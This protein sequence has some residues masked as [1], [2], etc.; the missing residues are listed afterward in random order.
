MNQGN[1]AA[2]GNIVIVGGGTAGWMAANLLQQAW[3]QRYSI[4]LIESPDIGIIGVGE[5]STPQLRGFFQKL[6]LPERDWMPRCHAT[7]KN[8]IRFFDWSQKPGYQAYFHPFVTEV[9]FRT[10]R[11]FVDNAYQR[12]CGFNVH[13][14]PDAFFLPSY[15]AANKRGPK[16]SVN[17]PFDVSYGY[18]F[19]SHLLGQYLSE[20]AVAAGVRHVQGKVAQVELQDS[21]DI[22]AVVL[23]DGQRFA[24]E[25]FVDSTGFRSLLLQQSLQVPFES[26]A[27]N[28]FNDSAVVIPTPADKVPNSE[29][30]ATA[31]SHGWAWNIPLTHRCGNGYVYSS[32]YC[33][34]EVAENELRQHL[35]SK[36]IADEDLGEAR[37][38]KMKV[39]QVQQHWA[40][41]CVAI[42]LAQGFIEPL[43]ATALHLVQET[44]EGFIHFYQKGQFSASHQAQFNQ[45]IRG[46]FDGVRDYIVCHYRASSRSDTPY[47]RDNSQNQHLSDNL[48]GLLAT[49]LQKG[50]ITQYLQQQ[51]MTGYYSTLS[52][53]CLLAGY[54]VFPDVHQGKLDPS[55]CHDMRGIQRFIE[56]CGLNFS[57]HEQQLQALV[58]AP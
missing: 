26:F 31:L 5:G 14:H 56:G 49:W 4:T 58:K 16:P 38:L 47:W 55:A 19:D 15:L 28:L 34:A 35:L 42:G 1:E 25:I 50:D 51:N 2:S 21:G 17:F 3:G 6:N 37:H 8:G 57:G 46:R 39:G 22:A 27:Q 11:A 10:A 52:W 30:Q 48:Q 40:K 54:G 20:V 36:G 53:H 23:E 29:T 32:R 9:D 13:A 44:I 7:Y 41:N 45:Q 33:S 18:H 43:E 24:A 12:R